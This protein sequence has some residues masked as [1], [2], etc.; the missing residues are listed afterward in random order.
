MA[1]IP[2][3]N[4]PNPWHHTAVDWIGEPPKARLQVYVDHTRRILS[5]NDSPDIPFRY[6]VNPYRGC[7]HA[8]A[9][10]YARP[11]H[12]Y[13]GFGA[14]TDFERRVVIKPD[15]PRLLEQA[16]RRPGWRGELV[17]F[18]GN[19]DCYQPLEAHY[20]LTR[21]C[22]E[23]CHRYRNPVAIITKGPL[24]E[25]DLDLLQALARDAWVAVT[26][27]VPFFD[28]VHARAIE[29]GVPPPARRLET[30]RRLAA[31]CVPVGVNVA[32][33]IPGLSD[34][35]ISDILGAAR[36]AGA[37][38][39]GHILVR[40]PGAVREVFEARVRA[41]LPDRADRILNRIRDTRGGQTN[42]PRFGHRMRGAG[43]YADAIHALFEGARRAHGYPAAGPAE[44][45][46]SPF[47]RPAA[48]S[49]QLSLGV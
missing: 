28:P 39:A 18:S 33:I 45:S 48:P 9:Y 7:L 36:A 42:D 24:I 23:V 31:A 25:R 17:V 34:S 12:E 46:P 40:L 38:W 1:L 6:S 5:R 2:I 22:L 26:V 4:P 3:D 13:L 20:G 27:S 47:R 8:C 14:G 30:I 16:F 29:P 44:P 10:C 35:Q 37:Q 19:T 21:A 32:P 15:A 11:S 41:A 49:R 43:T